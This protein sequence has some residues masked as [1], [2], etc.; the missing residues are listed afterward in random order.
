M[1]HKSPKFHFATARKR[2]LVFGRLWVRLGV[3]ELVY[4]SF[5]DSEVV[6]LLGVELAANRPKCALRLL[7]PSN[8]ELRALQASGFRDVD[9]MDSWQ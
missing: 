1:A 8:K 3:S 7:K 9:E 2:H 4:T 5:R 6:P